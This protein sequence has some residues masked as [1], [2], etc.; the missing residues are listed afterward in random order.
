MAERLEELGL[1]AGELVR[2]RRAESDRWRI[3]TARGLE[4]DGSLALTDVKGA[5]RAI[6]LG[7]V[8]VRVK[9][10]RGAQRWEPLQQR[11]AR[12]EQLP[13]L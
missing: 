2:F 5:A 3:G 4:R 7:L 6:P 8:E 10:P 12:E 9:G 11:A 1:K 13:L